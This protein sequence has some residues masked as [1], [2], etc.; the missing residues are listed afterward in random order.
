MPSLSST[1]NQTSDVNFREL[2]EITLL[3]ISQG[4]ETLEVAEADEDSELVVVGYTD[5]HSEILLHKFEGD[6]EDMP[7]II[8]AFLQ[9]RIENLSYRDAENSY[10]IEDIEM[11]T[12]WMRTTAEKSESQFLYD[13]LDCLEN[14]L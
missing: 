4:D 13:L 1:L 14:A 3:C 12:N 2:L 6:Y 8:E 11:F 7:V 9:K 10:E 5:H